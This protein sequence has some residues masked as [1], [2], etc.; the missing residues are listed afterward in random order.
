[1]PKSLTLTQEK[2]LWFAALVSA[3]TLAYEATLRVSLFPATTMP[4][5]ALD[6][7]LPFLPGWIIV[8]ASAA[9][10]AC[11]PLLT[12]TTRR[13]LRDTGFGYALILTVSAAAF[14]LWPTTFPPG[15]CQALTRHLLLNL[16]PTLPLDLPRN[17]CPSLHASIAVFAALCVRR[18]LRTPAARLAILAWPV[19]I[20]LSALLIKQH[21]L[22][23]LAAG[24][25][26]G[27]A[28]YQIVFRTRPAEA[29]DTEPV[30]ESVRIRR[31]LTEQ[32]PTAIRSLARLALRK[33]L[34]EV[35]VFLPLA[36][37]GLLL[38]AHARH[39]HSTPLL[40]AAIVGTAV[41]L[42]TFPLLVHEG[43]HGLLLPGRNGNWL[44]S[45]LLGSSFLMSFTAYRVLHI[46][47]HHYLGDPRDPDDYNNYARN[48]RIVWCMHFVR[49]AAGSLLY[50]FLI[51][52]LALRFATPAQRKLICVEYTLMLSIYSL[53]LHTFAARD[54]FF[55]WII[56]LLL[57]GTL[58]QIRGFA[59][60][61]ITDAQDPYL[62]SR[63]MLPHPVIAFFLLNENYHL[64][65]HLFPEVP[66]YHLAGLHRV[67]WPRL[68]RA[69]ASHSYLNF[70]SH[71]LG[72]T[73]RLD[74]TP[75]GFT[76]PL[77]A[78]QPDSSPPA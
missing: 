77:A 24:A 63:T 42:N 10:L 27:L 76:Q 59:Q 45:T 14:L 7:A 47:H 33:R 40:L 20:L 41:A 17:A 58:T 21:V 23:D 69:V 6:R 75:I 32:S 1:M 44:A 25:L 30:L 70:L 8:Y 72:A 5:T 53:L 66:S 22:L 71:F 3:A 62:A 2:L 26:L 60:H 37:A 12:L 57:V 49:L 74:Q 36:A 52:V 61:G 78:Q 34:R 50:V 13:E 18:A 73:P 15:F 38:G 4:L 35:A 19:L 28:V 51:P 68:P 9:L 67:L 39:I 16:T 65:H 48:P 46:R 43:M 29:P 31:R 54:L 11:L 64:E 56:P 55:V